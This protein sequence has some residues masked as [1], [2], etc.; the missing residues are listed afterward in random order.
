MMGYLQKT[1]CKYRDGFLELIHNT[2][3]L[4][5]FFDFHNFQNFQ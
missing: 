3:I 5:E 2:L 4:F 1:S